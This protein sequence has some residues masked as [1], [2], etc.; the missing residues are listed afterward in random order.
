MYR[1]LA[2]PSSFF[3]TTVIQLT[4]RFYVVNKTKYSLDFQQVRERGRGRM[5]V[6]VKVRVNARVGVG[7]RVRVK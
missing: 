6:R 4:P 1:A 3:R 7:V 2:C 5:K